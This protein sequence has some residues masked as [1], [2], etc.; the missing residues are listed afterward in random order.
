MARALGCDHHDVEVGARFDQAEVDVEAMRERERRAMLQVCM[1]I[2]GV[3]RGLMFVG[4]QDHDDIGPGGGIGICHD[5]EARVDRLCRG[6]RS[7]AECDS[8]VGDA[9]I[10]Q[11]LGV[12]MALRSI[13][14]DRDLLALDDAD[15]GVGIVVNAHYM[16]PGLMD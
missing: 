1:Q 8:D 13:T 7:C 9:R 15:V 6:R 2:V 12:S 10:L 4:R 5:A 16:C 3:D 11:V 14:E